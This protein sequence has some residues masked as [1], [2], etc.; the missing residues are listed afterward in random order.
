LVPKGARALKGLVNLTHLA[1]AGNHIGD[2]G[3]QALK[4]LVNLT[5]LD[6]SGNHIGDISPLLSLRNLRRINLS[7]NHLDHDVPEFWMLP[8]LQMAVLYDASLPGVPLEILSKDAEDNCLDRLRAHFADLTGDDVVV[9][10]IKL[11]ILGN[12]LVGKTQICRRLRGKSFDETVPSTHGIQVRSV[13]L[14]PQSVD[15]PVTLNIWD[16]GGQDIYHGTHSLFLK[17]RAVFP[18]VWTPKSE[19]EQFHTH[20]GFRFRNQ[21]LAYWLAYVRTFGGARSPVL[22]IQTQC[23]RPEDERDL[24]LT[25]GALDGFDYKKVL[26]YSAKG[27]GTHPRGHAALVETLLDAVQWMRSNEGVAKIGPGRAA[28]KEAL[29]AKL[30]A[31]HRLISHQS[32][33]D[34][35]AEVERTQKGRISN[36]ALLLDYLSVPTHSDQLFRLIP[37]SCSD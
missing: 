16:F 29:E 4:D 28:V 8:S 22:V 3:A 27:D 9:G 15:A 34:L 19:A 17:S 2:E 20:G 31:G 25:P 12:G 33:L 1:L 13:P 6:L 5:T 7:R 14:A 32:Y 18:V 10:D 37:I 11:M 24:P 23:D 35:C 30:A 26:H 21:P 36:A